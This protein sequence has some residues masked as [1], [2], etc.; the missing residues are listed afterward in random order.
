MRCA[1]CQ[2]GETQPGTTSVTLERSDATIVFRD[3]PAEVCENCGEA[4]IVAE[5]T[6]RLHQQ[7]EEAIASGAKIEVRS[8]AA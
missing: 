2:H 8:Y 7:A 6:T 4:Y 3:V 5:V 1:I